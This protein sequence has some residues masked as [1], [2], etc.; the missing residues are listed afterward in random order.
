VPSAEKKPWEKMRERNKE[1]RKRLKV[2]FQVLMNSNFPMCWQMMQR[3]HTQHIHLV[4][5]FVALV[6]GKD[7]MRIL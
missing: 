4:N 1:R 3:G 2:R 7:A 5:C 6:T